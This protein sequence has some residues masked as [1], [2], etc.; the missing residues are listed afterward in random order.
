MVRFTRK[1][2]FCSDYRT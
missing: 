1:T 2:N